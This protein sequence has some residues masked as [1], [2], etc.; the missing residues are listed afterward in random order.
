M[1]SSFEVAVAVERLSSHILSTQKP[2]GSRRLSHLP[3]LFDPVPNLPSPP[4]HHP[5]PF[6][7]VFSVFICNF[8]SSFMYVRC[9]RWLSYPFK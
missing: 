7:Q 4:A 8:S 5:R 9:R 2:L 3:V 1:V 6:W